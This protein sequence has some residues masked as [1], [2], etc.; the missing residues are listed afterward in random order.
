MGTNVFNP[1]SAVTLAANT[2]YDVVVGTSTL[3]GYWAW[4]LT[5]GPGSA[6]IGGQI[7]AGASEMNP[8]WQPLPNNSYGFDLVGTVVPEPSAMWIFALGGFAFSRK[9]R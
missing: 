9:R 3:D 6:G 7:L 2:T 1:A 8:S 5:Q 4:G